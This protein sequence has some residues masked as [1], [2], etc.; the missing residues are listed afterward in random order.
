MIVTHEFNLELFV[1]IRNMENVILRAWYHNTFKLYQR[2]VYGISKKLI[3]TR[4]NTK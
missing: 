3:N 2:T 1:G 4:T